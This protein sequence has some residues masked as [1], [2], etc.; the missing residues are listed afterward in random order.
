MLGAPKGL[1]YT[2]FLGSSPQLNDRGRAL[3]TELPPSTDSFKGV[4][5]PLKPTKGRKVRN[6]LADGKGRGGADYALRLGESLAPKPLR[7]PHKV[8][9]PKG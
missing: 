5:L 7:L 4:P 1:K 8:P 9:S 6:F 3:Y 2:I